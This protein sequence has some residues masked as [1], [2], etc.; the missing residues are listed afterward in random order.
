MLMC[1][2]YKNKTGSYR[3]IIFTYIMDFLLRRITLW[4]SLIITNSI[5]YFYCFY[6]IV[7]SY[8]NEKFLCAPRRFD[9]KQRKKLIKLTAKCFNSIL[10]A[11]PSLYPVRCFAQWFY[12]YSSLCYSWKNYILFFRLGGTMYLSLRKIS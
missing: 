4:F 5:Y 10:Q 7:Q 1:Q 2:F 9:T 12:M 11:F 3:V 6:L 8:V